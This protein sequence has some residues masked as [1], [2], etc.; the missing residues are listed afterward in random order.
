MSGA[1]LS[2]TFFPIFRTF[3]SRSAVLRQSRGATARWRFS[4]VP[5]MGLPK[6]RPFPLDGRKA[7]AHAR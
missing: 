3:L 6:I 2:I 4:A 5:F 1:L 7:F